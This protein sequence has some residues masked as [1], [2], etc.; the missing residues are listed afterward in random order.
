MLKISDTLSLPLDAA[1][2][3]FAFIARRGAG[4]TYT[5]GKLTELLMDAGIQCVVIDTVGNWYGLRLA[6]DGKGAGFDIPVLG[7]LRGDIPLEPAGGELVADLA[8][9]TGRSIILDMSQFNLAD[10]KRFATGFATRLW[11]RKKGERDPSPLHLVIEESQLIVP[12][13]VRGDDA[14]MVGIYEEIIRLGRNYGIGVS[15]ITQRPQ[16]TN[17]EVL[18]QT[19]CLVVLQVNGAQERKALREWIV[20]QGMDVNLV[21]ELPG[22]PVGTAYVWSPQWLRVL[23]KVKIAPKRTFDASATPK[24][25]V[26]RQ[27]RELAPLDLDAFKSKMVATIERAKENDPAQLRR[28]VSELRAQLARQPKQIQAQTKTV[29]VLV[30]D[31][32]AE[33]LFDKADDAF[34]QWRSSALAFEKKAEVVG[35]ELKALADVVRR[36]TQPHPL[37]IAPSPQTTRAIQ[38]FKNAPTNGH[39]VQDADRAPN[40]CERAILTALAQYPQGRTKNQIAILAGYSVTSG[41]FANS[42]AWLRTRDFITRGNPIQ[43]TPDGQAVLGDW[44]PLPVGR[45]LADY[46]L[47]NLNKCEREILRVLVEQY[48]QALPADQVAE[49][50]GYSRNSGGF[51]NALSKLRTLELITRGQPMKCSEDFF[52]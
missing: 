44:Q 23:Q 16:S 33:K 6:A 18:S 35:A 37:H 5:A 42:L 13:M 47:R 15:M 41:G 39:V 17:K 12:Q 48:P 46:W 4:K 2:Q 22:L 25:G 30:F 14:R 28:V 8:V 36:K 34:R 38:A 21:D 52:Q 19:E 49:A 10:R 40:K 32:N 50:T 51:A 27:Q 43:I 7:G 3:T 45:E 29:E 20:H 11:Q 26:R 24:V 9:E 31:K 1:T